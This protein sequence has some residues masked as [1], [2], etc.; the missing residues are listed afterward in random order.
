M[1]KYLAVG[2][3]EISGLPELRFFG[4]WTLVKTYILSHDWLLPAINLYP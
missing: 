2:H 1:V 4:Q 3:L